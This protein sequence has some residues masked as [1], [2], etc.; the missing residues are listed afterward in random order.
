MEKIIGRLRGQSIVRNKPILLFLTTVKLISPAIY[1]P[2]PAVS[3]PRSLTMKSQQEA[4]GRVTSRDQ[5]P[6]L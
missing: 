5:L 1:P 6:Y 4:H 3:I 2:A